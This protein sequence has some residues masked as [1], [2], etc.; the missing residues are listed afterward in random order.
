MLRLR[1]GEAVLA[2]YT[3]TIV[4]TAIPKVTCP[5]CGKQM[6]LSAIEPERDNR[7]RMTF[8]CDCGFTYS[9]SSAVAVERTL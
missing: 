3:Q 1:T 2:A 6:S 8:E 5:S 4:H 7:Q 9:H